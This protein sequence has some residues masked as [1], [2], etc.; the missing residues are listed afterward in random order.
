M[1]VVAIIPARGGSKGLARKNLRKIA[2]VSLVARAV[3]AALEAKLVDAAYVSTEDDEIVA[4]AVA[5]GAQVIQR[6]AELASDTAQNN[7]VLHHALRVLQE[8]GHEPEVLVLLQPT[9]PFR[10]SEHVNGALELFARTKAASVISICDVDHH[11]GKAVLLESG[12]VEP[13][14]NDRDMEARRQDMVQAFRQNGAIYITHVEEFR[15]SDSLFRRPCRGYVMDRRDSIDIDDEFDL[16]FAE[17][18][19]K[20][21][22]R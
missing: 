15:Q 1:R 2:G 16:E 18:M 9:S 20:T 17:F 19:S 7:A 13:F 3:R 6:P 12:L 5:C 8:Q 14:T 22:A 21:S 10:R 4:E 11:P